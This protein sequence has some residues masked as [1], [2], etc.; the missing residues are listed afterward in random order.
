[1]TSDEIAEKCG[2][3]PPEQFRINQEW[4]NVDAFSIHGA[5][6]PETPRTTTTRDVLF[7]RTGRTTEIAIAAA[8][9]ISEGV[10]VVIKAPNFKRQQRLAL[11]VQALCR[12][13]GIPFEGK[14]LGDSMGRH[15]AVAFSDHP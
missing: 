12:Q 15:R 13:A 3:E 10:E 8:A 11:R 5:L 14:I 9:A 1:M 2:L 6:G 7:R 4:K